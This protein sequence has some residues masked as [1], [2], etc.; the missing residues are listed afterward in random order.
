MNDI[1]RAAPALDG[2]AAVDERNPWLGLASF[3]EETQSYFYGREDEVWSC[4][5]FV[6]SFSSSSSSFFAS[7]L[8]SAV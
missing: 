4:P 1:H 2:N 7:I 8:P 3:T 6:D 5:G